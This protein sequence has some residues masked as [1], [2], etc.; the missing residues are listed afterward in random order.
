V[1]IIIIV[2]NEY[3]CMTMG[4]TITCE[5][6]MQEKVSKLTD[7]FE[8][9]KV[10]KALMDRKLLTRV[11]ALEDKTKDLLTKNTEERVSRDILE[12]RLCEFVQNQVVD[13]EKRMEDQIIQ[14][15]MQIRDAM[16]EFTNFITDFHQMKSALRSQHRDTINCREETLE[17][18][19]RLR[20][21]QKESLAER[22]RIEESII[23]CREQ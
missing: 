23:Q 13:L 19:D 8:S 16:V 14:M 12:E 9:F 17:I 20:G 15:K 4:E 21:L 6:T 18:S 10:N 2:L 7:L 1:N 5:Q 3:C 22:I 11:I